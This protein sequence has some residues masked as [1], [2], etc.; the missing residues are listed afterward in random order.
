MATKKKR[1]KARVVFDQVKKERYKRGFF[2]LTFS[3]LI[4]FLLLMVVPVCL[5]VANIKLVS[6][7]GVQIIFGLLMVP[8]DIVWLFFAYFFACGFAWIGKKSGFLG[9]VIFSVYLVIHLSL[10]AII[11]LIHL[12]A[13]LI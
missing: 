9:F 5:W 2:A 1:V 3:K 7:L 11:L 6:Q 12:F 4:W 8:L 13:G 10:L